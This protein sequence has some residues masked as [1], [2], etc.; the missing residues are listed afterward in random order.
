MFDN[1]LRKFETKIK[2]SSTRNFIGYNECREYGMPT[3]KQVFNQA[4]REGKNLYTKNE[5]HSKFLKKANSWYKF[6]KYVD[7]SDT[8]ESEIPTLG[9]FIGTNLYEFPFLFSGYESKESLI[10]REWDKRYR[11]TDE[12]FYPRQIAGEIIVV[13]IMLNQYIEFNEL[14]NYVNVFRQVHKVTPEENNKLV[15]SGQKSSEFISPEVC[16]QNAGIELIKVDNDNSEMYY[17]EDVTPRK[18]MEKVFGNRL[19]QIDK[20]TSSGKGCRT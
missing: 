12:H 11:P 2:K 7:F 13:H 19:H 6:F 16:Y 9:R 14:L 1:Y 4:V 20:Y 5:R 18:V 10:R 17:L 15:Y 8:E 3:A